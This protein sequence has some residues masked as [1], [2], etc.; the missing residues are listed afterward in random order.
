MSGIFF[1]AGRDALDTG[2]TIYIPAKC[3]PNVNSRMNFDW[4]VL[5]GH[6]AVFMEKVIEFDPEPE[7]ESLRTSE[8]FA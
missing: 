6:C 4:T 2:Q 1:M 3:Q 8:S 5:Q 7:A